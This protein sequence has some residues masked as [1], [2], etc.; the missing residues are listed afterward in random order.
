MNAT[1]EDCY[2]FEQEPAIPIERRERYAVM[3][4]RM[5][6]DVAVQSEPRLPR[7][8]GL[9]RPRSCGRR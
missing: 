1:Y 5:V 9:E 2:A 7:A 4:M 6:S 8:G 3:R